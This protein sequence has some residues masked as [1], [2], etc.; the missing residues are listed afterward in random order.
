MFAHYLVA[1]FLFFGLRRNK[2]A[3]KEAG[4][5]SGL[6]VRGKY[7]T[8]I[9]KQGY[10][11]DLFESRAQEL[12]THTTKDEKINLAILMANCHLET[13]GSPPLSVST[14]RGFAKAP[15]TE[16]I[17]AMQMLSKLPVFCSA[18]ASMGMK[19]GFMSHSYTF[20]I[21]NDTNIKLDEITKIASEASHETR[22][23]IDLSEKLLKVSAES[24]SYNERLA[25]S[26]EAMEKG[27]AN[28]TSDLSSMYEAVSGF[29]KRA[30]AAAKMEQE[31]AEMMKNF[32][33]E[34]KHM[35]GNIEISSGNG[36]LES[37]LVVENMQYQ[38]ILI[39]LVTM[40]I[41]SKTS[42]GSFIMLFFFVLVI[43]IVSIS[44]LNSSENVSLGMRLINYSNFAIKLMTGYKI[45]V[46]QKL[47]DYYVSMRVLIEPYLEIDTKHIVIGAVCIVVSVFLSLIL[48][49]RRRRQRTRDWRDQQGKN[50]L[51]KGFDVHNCRDVIDLL[52]HQEKTLMQMRTEIDKMLKL[53]QFAYQAGSKS[54]PARFGQ[55]IVPDPAFVLQ[56]WRRSP[57]SLS[58]GISR[59][60]SVR[61]SPLHLPSP[62]FST[63]QKV[64]IPKME[65]KE[66]AT[67]LSIEPADGQRIKSEPTIRHESS[68]RRNRKSE[69][70]ITSNPIASDI[71]PPE[72]LRTIESKGASK[73]EKRKRKKKKKK[74]DKPLL[75][76]SN[77]E[78]R[79]GMLE[80]YENVTNKAKKRSKKK[81]KRS[82]PNEI[83]SPATQEVVPMDVSNNEEENI[84]SIS[85]TS[86]KSIKFCVPISE[87]SSTTHQGIAISFRSNSSSE[88]DESSKKRSEARRHEGESSMS[89]EITP[90]ESEDDERSEK[91]SLS[92]MTTDITPYE[93]QEEENKQSEK[94]SESSMTTSIT[95]YSS[96]DQ[97]YRYRENSEST[98]SNS[99]NKFVKP[100]QESSDEETVETSEEHIQKESENSSTSSS[101]PNQN[102]INQESEESSK[103]RSTESRNQHSQES[104]E[105][106]SDFTRY[107]GSHTDITSTH[108]TWTQDEFWHNRN[109]YTKVSDIPRPPLPPR[110]R[111][112]AKSVPK[113]D[114]EE[115]IENSTIDGIVVN[116]TKDVV[117]TE[118][119]NETPIVPKTNLNDKKL[120]VEMG[121]VEDE[122]VLDMNM[123]K[124]EVEV[125]KLEAQKVLE[126]LDTEVKVERSKKEE[127]NIDKE[128]IADEKPIIPVWTTAC[129][130][131][132]VEIVSILDVQQVETEIAEEEE[133]KKDRKKRKKSSKLPE[134]NESQMSTNTKRKTRSTKRK[135]LEKGGD[136]MS[137]TGEMEPPTAAAATP[138]TRRRKRRVTQ[139][140]DTPKVGKQQGEGVVETRRR[141]R[142]K[143]KTTD[144][145]DNGEDD[146]SKS[147]YML[148]RLNRE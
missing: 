38:I 132:T 2:G 25:K 23:S 147:S 137:E 22:K 104:E 83:E 42:V 28:F 79:E 78:E 26:S 24:M 146:E 17:I 65:M 85:E 53:V 55:P 6:S 4:R 141:S 19:L 126:V 27:M 46:K 91:G 35:I 43:G 102:R 134:E 47:M 69:S 118:K 11:C 29:E 148:R 51:L 82:L 5:K 10:H 64:D 75:D 39:V 107:D 59:T 3:V 103:S 135:V 57:I 44:T 101:K 13:L 21:L 62:D 48:K 136:L 86:T 16:K 52:Q 87:T 123:K 95:T 77:A 92:S 129:E 144:V 49:V 93:S 120:G 125:N 88:S 30:E 76:S 61:N 139:Q 122:K 113:L 34:T 105:I 8:E 58:Y 138:K 142:R 106:E 130:E 115:T 110:L 45:D 96:E 15:D 108:S 63:N 18:M 1:S 70:K 133:G 74:I 89:T 97:Q 56:K 140:V 121:K 36:Y 14:S 98:D 127:A 116:A 7:S 67:R 143:K 66:E 81:R 50:D 54:Q 111:G 109:G 119:D 99:L 68:R 128:V 33:E 124:S 84:N 9:V 80:H 114:D 40:F 71:L 131:P 12:C 112:Y 73:E 94:I 90:Y 32:T 20:D 117:V 60:A 72:Q 145:E 100:S 37:Q 31:A 41:F